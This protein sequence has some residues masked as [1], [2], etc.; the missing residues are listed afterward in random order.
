MQCQKIESTML[1]QSLHLQK[2]GFFPDLVVL[3]KG[4]GREGST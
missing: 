4:K 2:K 1:E 3:E